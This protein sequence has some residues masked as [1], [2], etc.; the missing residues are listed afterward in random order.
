MVPTKLKELKVQFQE[1]LERNL[2]HN[3]TIKN[4][5]LLPI[6]DEL[7]DQ[8]QGAMVFSKFDPRQGYYISIAHKEGRR[9]TKLHLVPDKVIMHL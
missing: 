4:K 8:L 9:F 2:S 6:I 7:F 5:Y 1:L 3:I